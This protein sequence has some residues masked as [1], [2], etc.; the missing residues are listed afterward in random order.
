MKQTL[1]AVYGKVAQ[2]FPSDLQSYIW[3]GLTT[4][5]IRAK[6]LKVIASENVYAVETDSV[7]LKGKL[8]TGEGLGDWKL[9]SEFPKGVF[10]SESQHFDLASRGAEEREIR[11]AFKAGE[12]S[13]VFRKRVFH[14]G[15][16]AT[17][18]M[19][20]CRKCGKSQ[21]LSQGILCASC[22][23]VAGVPRGSFL[24]TRPYGTWGWEGREVGLVRPEIPDLG[25]RESEAFRPEKR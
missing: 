22:G 15:R 7:I 14:D 8:P 2:R 24:E 9:R 5:L 18:A 19:V 21:S 4:S 11:R 23:V 12:E 17:I 1:A 6:L 13:A 10:F 20:R 25:G 3:A 16:S